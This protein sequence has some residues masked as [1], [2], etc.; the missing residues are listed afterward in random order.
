M[1]RRKF[2]FTEIFLSSNSIDE[3]INCNLQPESIWC[4]P[5]I[6]GNNSKI[7]FASN[8]YCF[9][10]LLYKIITNNNPFTDKNERK[11]QKKPNLEL[12]FELK[13][14]IEKCVDIEPNN[15]PS[16][17]EINPEIEDVEFQNENNNSLIG[18][19]NNISTISSGTSHSNNNLKIESQ[20]DDTLI[21]EYIQKDDNK[22]NNNL[23]I[24]NKKKNYNKIISEQNVT[25][26]SIIKNEGYEINKISENKS[27]NNE[28]KIE[29]TNI[30]SKTNEEKNL[31]KKYE[32]GI[33]FKDIENEDYKLC[34]IHIDIIH[35]EENPIE[36]E[37][38]DVYIDSKKGYTLR[39]D[40]ESKDKK[41]YFY[42]S[43]YF[44]FIIIME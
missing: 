27:I 14:L 12:N 41:G 44:H 7:S 26:F 38:F 34:Y 28:G 10:D 15:R 5:E 30:K 9:G 33:T 31:K 37:I 22:I 1:D 23:N 42:F 6:K 4:C 29:E 40:G 35:K 21:N 2:F 36:M 13:S 8:I 24:G 43:Q 11:I 32:D 16:L 39:K 19:I 17:D 3:I 25:E 20:I 18:I